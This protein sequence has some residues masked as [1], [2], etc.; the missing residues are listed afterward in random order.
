LK[1]CVHE[2]GEFEKGSENA[3]NIFPHTTLEKFE[4]ATIPGL[5]IY[6]RGKFRQG[7]HQSVFCPQ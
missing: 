6:I 4:N 2:G 7:V 5:W 1:P 3:S